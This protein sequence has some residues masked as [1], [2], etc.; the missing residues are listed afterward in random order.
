MDEAVKKVLSE[1]GSNHMRE[2]QPLGNKTFCRVALPN[3]ARL[4]IYDL[5]L[6]FNA[7]FNEHLSLFLNSIIIW[8]VLTL[9]IVF[10]VKLF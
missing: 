9:K 6:P 7:L 2:K 10:Q 4:Q 3:T 5:P 8:P 1:F